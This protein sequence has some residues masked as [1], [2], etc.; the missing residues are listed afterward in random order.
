MPRRIGALGLRISANLTLFPRA[1]RGLENPISTPFSGDNYVGMFIP[2][3]CLR[4]SVV[5]PLRFR[6]I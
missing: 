1:F 6:Y 5:L 4:K 2:I 3:L